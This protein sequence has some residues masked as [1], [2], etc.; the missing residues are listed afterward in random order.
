MPDHAPAPLTT[1]PLVSLA[2]ARAAWA[3]PWRARNEILRLLL[4]PWARWRVMTSPLTWERGWRFYGMPVLQIHRQAQ[5]RIGARLNLRSTLWS[6]P[7][8][9]GHPVVLS[10]RRPGAAL[11]IGSDFGMTGGVIVCEERITIGDRVLVGANSSIIDTDFHPLDPTM[12]QAD[13]LAGAT[14]PI[15]IEDDV[16]IGMEVMVLK[17]A[18]IGAGS[19]IGARSVVTGRIPPGVIAA[20]S[21]ARVVRALDPD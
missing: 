16:F 20:G 4:W 6:N 21:P 18:H 13:P 5:V 12:R 1:P 15:V 10:A 11:T 19:V 14:R 2:A 9:P 3:T 17:G 7:L 8:A